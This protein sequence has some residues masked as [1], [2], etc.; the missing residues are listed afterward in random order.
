M[1]VPDPLIDLP[2]TA[3]VDTATS[4]MPDWLYWT[5]LLSVGVFWLPAYALAIH[6]ARVDRRVGIPVLLVPVNLAWEFTH[7]LVLEQL[8]E[9]RPLNF[10][11]MVL[12]LVILAQAL[13]Y[14]GRDTGLSPGAFRWVVWGT[15]G[16]ASVFLV[17][18]TFEFGDFYG[19]YTGLGINIALSLA[20][21][22]MLHRR[23][24]SAGQCLYVAFGKWLGTLMV[25]FLFVGLYPERHLLQLLA[26]SVSALDI[27]YIV[28]LRRRIRAEGQSPWTLRRPPVDVARGGTEDIAVVG[29]GPG[30]GAVS[31]ATTD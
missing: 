7:S 8:P 16:Y 15:L 1:W 24:S 2:A 14:G 10:G 19:I 11:A 4:P 31:G 12:D 30:A 21:L 3:P 23:G 29:V 27:A 26:A 22:L 9:Q 6:R 13:R 18:L 5:L 17:T 20:F 28:L 25:G